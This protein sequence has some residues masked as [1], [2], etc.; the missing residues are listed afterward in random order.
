MDF[1]KLEV[2][3][4][5][6]YVYSDMRSL[7]DCMPLDEAYKIVKYLNKVHTKDNF[8]FVIEIK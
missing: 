7:Y 5:Q 8:Y 6:V 2:N 3:I 4:Y 1:N